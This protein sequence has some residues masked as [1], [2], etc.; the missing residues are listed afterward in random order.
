MVQ[1]QW[2]CFIS[3]YFG[4]KQ[5]KYWPEA[6]ASICLSVLLPT[7]AVGEFGVR[8]HKFSI[9]S[10]SIVQVWHGCFKLSLEE[11][12]T[13]SWDFLFCSFLMCFYAWTIF[14]D[15]N[16]KDPYDLPCLFTW[17]N[18]IQS[19]C[20]PLSQSSHLADLLAESPSEGSHTHTGHPYQNAVIHVYNSFLPCTTRV[21]RWL[22]IEHASKT[23]LF[24]CF[25]HWKVSIRLAFAK[26]LL[27]Y[28]DS[29]LKRS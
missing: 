9:L 4:I 12:K 11:P 29:A 16:F 26:M 5:D 25:H 19:L 8:K 6:P 14:S 10:W 23:H 28:F 2:F 17:F 1:F 27:K 3:A 24:A 20:I 7:A 21:Q 18:H 22:T 15:M 13:S